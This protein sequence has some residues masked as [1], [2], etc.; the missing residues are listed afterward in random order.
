MSMRCYYDNDGM[1]LTACSVERKRTGNR[2]VDSADR[3][4][5]SLCA[6]TSHCRLSLSCACCLLLSLTACVIRTLPTLP[7]PLSPPLPPMSVSSPPPL[8]SCGVDTLTSS[9]YPLLAVS[10]ALSL[11]LSHCAP[12]SARSVRVWGGGSE[13]VASAAAGCVLSCDVL[14]PAPFPPFR[15][16]TMDGYAIH[17]SDGAGVYRVTQ[18]ITAGSAVSTPLPAGEVAYITTGAPL[19]D[20]ADA[21]IMVERSERG[22]DGTVSQQPHTHTRHFQ[23]SHTPRLATRLSLLSS[24]VV[25]CLPARG[26]EFVLLSLCCVLCRVVLLGTLRFGCWTA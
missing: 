19:P 13:C 8:H 12:L 16:S 24:A 4:R 23:H 2:S 15:A 17:S 20:Q 21:V 9:P 11:V 26:A 10:D 3:N 5:L 7:T 18:R 14:S 25:A 6:H 1:I 22:E